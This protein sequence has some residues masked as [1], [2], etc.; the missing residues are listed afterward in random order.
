M[1]SNVPYTTLVSRLVVSLSLLLGAVVFAFL[2]VAALW[3]LID[4]PWNDADEPF[5]P[6]GTYVAIFSG[7]AVLFLTFALALGM[8]IVRRMRVAI[9]PESRA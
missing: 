7:L 3:Q 8:L 1:P 4:Q 9:R 6:D 5:W 2:G